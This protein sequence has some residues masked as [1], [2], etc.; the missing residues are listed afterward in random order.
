MWVRCPRWPS[1]S[2]IVSSVVVQLP[3]RPRLLAV[4]V[5]GVR[6]AQLVDRP[7]DRPDDL[8]RRH[9]EVV[10][11]RVEVLTFPA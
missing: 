10:D 6:Q 1:S 11:R 7:G 3:G 8:P 5:H 4:D 9:A 2:F